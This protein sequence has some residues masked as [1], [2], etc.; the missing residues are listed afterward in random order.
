MKKI[1]LLI[2][3]IACLNLTAQ[4]RPNVEGWRVHLPYQK[5]I[6]VAEV[7]N[8]IY[9]GSPS[10]IFTVDINDFAIERLSKITGL[11][12]VEV[13]LVRHNSAL[14]LTIIVYQNANIDIVDHKA[15]TII[16]LPDL[17]QLNVIGSK[18]INNICLR[19]I[20]RF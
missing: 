14:N 5:A 7:G 9:V 12:D 19:I 18:T 13:K 16:N 10:G 11:S 3:S 15:N 2:F 8:K 6:T 20:I 1:L 4:Q 17:L